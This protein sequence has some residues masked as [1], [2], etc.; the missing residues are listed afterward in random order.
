MT[1]D[2]ATPRPWKVNPEGQEEYKTG[3]WEITSNIKFGEDPDDT[4]VA[5]CYS[6]NAQDAEANARLIVKAINCHDELVEAL[7]KSQSAL[8][9][10]LKYSHGDDLVDLHDEAYYANI[11]INEALSK[12]NEV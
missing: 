1:K 4:C 9:S 8:N 5:L 11:K 3:S 7:K 2:N 10:V 12:A 6:Y